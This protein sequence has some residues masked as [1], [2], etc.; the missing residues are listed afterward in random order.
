MKVITTV[1]LQLFLFA[2]CAT[3]AEWVRETVAVE[4]EVW[5]WCREDLDPPETVDKG[6]CYTEWETKNNPWPRKNEARAVH[7]FCAAGDI[8]CLKKRKLTDKWL[9]SNPLF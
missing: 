7:H 6:W 9:V 8:D 1:A 3:T 5:N 4:D 2:A